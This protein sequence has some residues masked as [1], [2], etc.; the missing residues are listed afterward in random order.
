MQLPHGLQDRMIVE[1]RLHDFWCAS[2]RIA[3]QHGEAPEQLLHPLPVTAAPRRLRRPQGILH[4]P[5]QVAQQ[6]PKL[7]FRLWQELRRAVCQNVS[8]DQA[9]GQVAHGPLA[10]VGFAPLFECVENGFPGV[11][12]LPDQLRIAVD[13]AARIA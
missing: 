3:P 10:R 13:P 1:E 6:P 8:G 9:V 11:H 2:R 5:E 12:T 4:V 7:L